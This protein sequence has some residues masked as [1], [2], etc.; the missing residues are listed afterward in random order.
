MIEQSLDY[1]TL[2]AIIDE[3]N[4]IRILRAEGFTPSMFEN[5]ECVKVY[6]YIR[7]FYNDFGEMPTRDT[8]DTVFQDLPEVVEGEQGLRFQIDALRQRE[9]YSISATCINSCVNILNSSDSENLISGVDKV[10]EL[11]KKA[12]T[13]LTLSTSSADTG[14]I[15]KEK[16]VVKDLYEEAKRNK[17]ILGIPSFWPTLTAMTRGFRRGHT[18]MFLAPEGTGKTFT[19]LFN[20][21]KAA[22]SGY[23][24]L[25]Y[26]EEMPRE[27]LAMRFAAI[28]CNIPYGKLMDGDL[29]PVDERT[30]YDYIESED[31]PE[32]LVN[33]GGGSQG[34]DYIEEMARQIRPD[35]I[36]IDNIYLYSKRGTD[37]EALTEL[38]GRAKKL[39]M[40]LQIPVV[41]CTQ[42]NEKGD[43]FGS[44][45]FGFD[46]TGRFIIT[47]DDIHARAT[48]SNTKSRD[49]ETGK[50]FEV[51]W[52]FDSMKFSEVT[53]G[54]AP[55]KIDE[56]SL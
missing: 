23:K 45:S 16:H 6:D 29:E 22:K 39:A 44:R 10:V 21:L 54:K 2:N 24:P 48:I 15:S 17:G 28:Y 32:F 26:T 11:L 14:D 4:A 42:M 30:F 40:E 25:F 47:K 49:S 43:S 27:E 12:S 36:F 37:R 33:Q 53:K 20:A 55:E 52:K 35:I 51:H 31:S 18:Y 13:D 19:L 38:S 7:K 34:M 1:K 5:D 46:A 50:E 8:L 41:F 9:K 3:P 56:D